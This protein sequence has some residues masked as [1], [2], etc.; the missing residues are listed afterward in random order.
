MPT[1]ALLN[2]VNDTMRHIGLGRT[3]IYELIAAGRLD[4]RKAGTKTLITGESI[5][6]Y[7]ASLPPAPIASK[8]AA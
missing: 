7:G 3:R 8:P 6:A 5:M 1:V 2:S 4:A